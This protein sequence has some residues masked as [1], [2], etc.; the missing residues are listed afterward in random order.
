MNIEKLIPL[1]LEEQR[2]FIA[3][4]GGVQTTPIQIKRPSWMDMITNYPDTSVDAI[5][6]YTDIGNGLLKMYQNNSNAWENTCAFRMSKGLNYSGFKLPYDNSKYRT[7]GSS[8]GVHKG[9]DKLN[10][11]YRVKELGKYLEEHLGSPEFDETLKKVGLGEK[12]VGLSKE[13]W[14][15]LN[16]MKGIIM[17]KVSGWGNASGHFTLWDGSHLI[18]PGDPLHDN[19]N[20]QYYYFHMKYEQNSKVIQTD[21][22]KLWE[23]K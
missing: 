8:G 17:F 3:T 14:D 18:Y 2:R 20:S 19:P 21:E 9:D 15:R 5:T 13:N 10:Y 16:K 4:S 7:K 6:L 11:W 1:L 12:K 23:L 22:I